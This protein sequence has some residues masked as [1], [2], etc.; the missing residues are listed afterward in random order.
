M[1]LIK[2]LSSVLYLFCFV[3]FRVFFFE[4]ESHYITQASNELFLYRPKTSNTSL[5]ASQVLCAQVGNTPLRK[6]F[7][8][9]KIFSD[10]K[11]KNKQ[12]AEK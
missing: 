1:K 9:L 7:S 2:P 11:W 3:W 6:A 8:L 5:S 12:K 10:T 4:V